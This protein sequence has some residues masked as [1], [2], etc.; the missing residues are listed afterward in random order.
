VRFIDP[1]LSEDGRLRLVA[2]SPAHR[3]SNQFYDAEETKKTYYAVDEWTLSVFVLNADEAD[4]PETA[5]WVEETS[6]TLER[7]SSSATRS[8]FSPC[9]IPIS[10]SSMCQTGT[11]TD[12]FCRV[13][14]LGGYQKT[15]TCAKSIELLP[16]PSDFW[17]GAAGENAERCGGPEGKGAIILFPDF[18]RAA[19]E[20]LAQIRGFCVDL[21][22]SGEGFDDRAGLYELNGQDSDGVRGPDPRITFDTPKMRQTTSVTSTYVTVRATYIRGKPAVFGNDI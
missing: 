5:S 1:A 15:Q 8:S 2:L 10:I 9:Q 12:P 13:P 11:L 6:I 22:T 21:R 19:T 18:S 20:Q 7:S 14:D 16:I 17:P 3:L 4:H